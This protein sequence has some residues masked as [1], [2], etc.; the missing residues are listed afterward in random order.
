M[1]TYQELFRTPEFTP[2]FSTVSA[3]VAASTVSG[4]ALGTLVYSSTHSPLLSALSMFGSSFA[5]VVGAAFLLSAADRLPPRA[6]LTALALAFGIGTAVLALPGLPIWGLFAV[7]LA[8][9]LL[10]SLGGGVRYGLLS[11]I[12]PKDGYV[13]G[14]SAMNMSVGAMQICGFAAG[15]ALVTALSP[16]GT[17][18]I[19]AALDLLGAALARYG[20]SPRPPRTAGRATF[21]ETWHTNARLWSSRP[22]RYVYLA[23]WVPNGLIVGCEALFVP[24]SPRYAGLLFAVAATGMLTGDLMVGRVIPQRWRVR[25]AAPLRLLL[26]VP[27]LVFAL[28][29]PLPIAFCAIALA[30]AGYAASLVL[31]ERLITLTPEDVHGQALGLHSSGMLTMQ[32]V[33]ATVAGLLAQQ[34]TPAQAMAVLAVA[35]VVVTLLLGPGLRG[36]A[37][38]A[39]AEAERTAGETAEEPQFLQ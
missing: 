20:L 4:I 27:Y 14:R 16:R 1:R 9:G 38:P 5:Q 15:G 19:A 11:E 34:L 10:S 32:A 30:S 25:L 28:R 17:L 36:E 31:Q 33:G 2:F 13:L 24:Y 3:T 6:T 8:L 22:R 18:L 12:V 26:A 29:P 7:V 39:A 21:G 23:L 37:G 35:S